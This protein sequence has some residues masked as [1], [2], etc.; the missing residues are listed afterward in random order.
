MKALLS[1]CLFIF[2]VSTYAAD[3][4]IEATWSAPTV[5]EDGTA[6]A[7][8]EIAGY[9]LYSEIPGDIQP[10]PVDVKDTTATSTFPEV[11]GQYC[12]QLSTI[13]KQGLESQR[14]DRHCLNYALP[15]PIDTIIIPTP[16]GR[17]KTIQLQFEVRE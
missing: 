1:L 15:D 9:R 16:P 12:F 17:L 11:A 6:L 8:D 3:I 5:R 14:S 7:A 2:S 10:D 4:I 13:D